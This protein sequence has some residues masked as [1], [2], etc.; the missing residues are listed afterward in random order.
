MHAAR[1]YSL[2]VQ[3]HITASPYRLILQQVMVHPPA[4]MSSWLTAL[5]TLQ[6]G[7]E[8]D[9]DEDPE[10]KG[11]LSEQDYAKLQELV[12]EQEAAIQAGESCGGHCRGPRGCLQPARSLH[13]A[14]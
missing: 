6:G 14:A 7:Q 4:N 12:D 2:T 11:D 1:Q 10:L 8:G 9:P 13:A 3:P 5:Q